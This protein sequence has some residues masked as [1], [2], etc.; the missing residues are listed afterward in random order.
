MYQRSAWRSIGRRV[1][2][3]LLFPRK[4]SEVVENQPLDVGMFGA[5]Q[6]LKV[7]RTPPV[8]VWICRTCQQR[9]RGLPAARRS[10]HAASALC[11]EGSR[12]RRRL[13][14]ALADRFA[15]ICEDMRDI[16]TVKLTEESYPVTCSVARSETCLLRV[17]RASGTFQLLQLVSITWTRFT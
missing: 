13:T 14:F 11:D 4:V 6:D 12:C 15:I 10:S 3:T 5:E 2:L 7:M 17:S 16:W 9:T 8:V 1:I